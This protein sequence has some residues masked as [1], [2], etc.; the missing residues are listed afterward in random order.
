MISRIHS[1]NSKMTPSAASMNQGSCKALVEYLDKE[2]K[3]SQ[4]SA[5]FFTHDRNSIDADEAMRMIDQNHLKLKRNQD[6][7]FM[8]TINPSQEELR[9]IIKKTTGLV[10][11]DFRSLPMSERA[12]V[13]DALRGYARDVM[14]NYAA[15]FNREG[16][17]DGNDLVY[18]GKIETKRQYKADDPDVKLGLA[19]VGSQKPGLQLH[20]H[21]CVSRNS[22]DQTKKLSPLGAGARAANRKDKTG[23]SG[24]NKGQWAYMNARHCKARFGYT[25]PLHFSNYAQ[26]RTARWS[27]EKLSHRHV[28][29]DE[30]QLSHIKTD[31]EK[32]EWYYTAMKA[33]RTMN[34]ARIIDKNL[35]NVERQ[36][37][38]TAMRLYRFAQDPAGSLLSELLRFLGSS[39]QA[40]QL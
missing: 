36:V 7:F 26:E 11:D 29:L 4:G 39:S 8:L 37:L 27:D 35:F 14:D 22:R 21:I 1:P 12:K 30:E 20:I 6:K 9:E 23:K 2:G 28:F 17:N 19:K 32:L 34:G 24:F 25:D 33:K 31:K 10:C 38:N 16:I 18:F 13:Y 3:N 40:A 15:C 5:G